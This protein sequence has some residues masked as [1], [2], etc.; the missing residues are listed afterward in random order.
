MGGRAHHDQID[1][2]QIRSHEPVSAER[3]HRTC[4]LELPSN[5][6][7]DRLG[8]AKPGVIDNQS[9]HVHLSFPVR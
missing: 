1:S 9:I 4:R 6:L 7:R 3:S 8:I 2:L 5:C